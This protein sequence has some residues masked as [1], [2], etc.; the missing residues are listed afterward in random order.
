MLSILRGNSFF[1]RR[2][3]AVRAL[4]KAAV[5]EAISKGQLLPTDEISRSAKGPWLSI[6]DFR[7]SANDHTRLARPSI[8]RMPGRLVWT[9]ILTCAA[10]VTILYAV[11]KRLTMS[12]SQME[13]AANAPITKVWEDGQG[14]RV[15]LNKEEIEAYNRNASGSTQ[16][17]NSAARKKVNPIEQSFIDQI[18]MP[19]SLRAEKQPAFVNEHRGTYTASEK[20]GQ[21]FVSWTKKKYEADVTYDIKKTDSIISPFIAVVDLA[22]REYSAEGNPNDPQGFHRTRQSVLEAGWRSDVVA[23]NTRSANPYTFALKDGV[24]VYTPT[25]YQ[26]KWFGDE[27]PG[28]WPILDKKL[29]EEQSRDWQPFNE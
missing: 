2:G 7:R 10:C 26:R 21:A 16:P 15:V 11:N 20:A 8:A 19:I 5:D 4:R 22:L 14:N 12:V 17:K 6:A 27:T 3:S 28:P 1:V 18:L 25:D 24:W 23:A 9:A 29:Y 13:R